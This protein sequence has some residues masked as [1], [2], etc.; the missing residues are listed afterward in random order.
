MRVTIKPDLSCSEEF[1][2]AVN[3]GKSELLEEFVASNK[4]AADI[5]YLEEV[6]RAD[7]CTALLC[8]VK[9]ADLVTAQILTKAGARTVVPST[10][11]SALHIVLDNM[12]PDQQM[13]DFLLR[14]GACP[15]IPD[16]SGRTAMEYALERRASADGY[17][18]TADHMGRCVMSFIQARNAF[19]GRVQIM[20]KPTGS[21]SW[22]KPKP[23]W[24]DRWCAL[25]PRCDSKGVAVETELLVF[26]K[27]KLRLKAT[28]TATRAQSSQQ[29]IPL[30]DGA[31]PTSTVALGLPRQKPSNMKSLEGFKC[32]SLATSGY[33]IY[34]GL[35]T[36]AGTSSSSL[37]LFMEQVAKPPS[38]LFVSSSPNTASPLPFSPPLGPLTPQAAP[39]MPPVAS[40]VAPISSIPPS[41]SSA[42][43]VTA[44]SVT[45]PRSVSTPPAVLSV[46]VPAAASETLTTATPHPIPSAPPCVPSTIETL[47]H[48]LSATMIIPPAECMTLPSA[49]AIGT[50]AQ[51][52]QSDPDSSFISPSQLAHPVH[53][54]TIISDGC[55]LDLVPSSMSDSHGL[56]QPHSTTSG[57]SHAQPTK[58]RAAASLVSSPNPSQL[59]AVAAARL[60]PP[61]PV[62]VSRTVSFHRPAHLLCLQHDWQKLA[63]QC[64]SLGT[65]LQL[66][67]QGEVLLTGPGTS[68]ADAM[69]VVNSACEACQSNSS[70][71]KLN[72]EPHTAALFTHP[73]V[74]ATGKRLRD[75]M[76]KRH[77]VWCEESSANRHAASA[78]NGI[79]VQVVRGNLTQQQVAAIV[80]PTNNQLGLTGGVSK[81]IAKAAGP[82]LEK[83]CQALLASLPAGQR[84]VPVGSSAVT[85]CRGKSYKSIPCQHIIHAVGPHYNGNSQLD[86]P[87][88]ASTVQSVLTQAAAKGMHSVAM[89]LIGAGLAG[90][91]PKLAA[92]VHVAQ[93]W[94]FSGSTGVPLKEVR[95]VDLNDEAIAALREQV[96][97]QRQSFSLSFVGSPA[98]CAAA[99]QDMQDQIQGH[100]TRVQ[101]RLCSFL[102][103]QHRQDMLQHYVLAAVLAQLMPDSL[104]LEGCKELVSQAENYVL[105]LNAEAYEEELVRRQAL[106]ADWTPMD[107][108]LN[109]QLFEVDSASPE[110]ASLVQALQQTGA[111][112]IKVH[113]IQNKLLWAAY[114]SSLA[115]MKVR[116][117]LE[118][119]L[120]LVNGGAS[121]LWH[122]TSKADPWDICAAEFGFM[123]NHA[124]LNGLWGYG[125]YYSTTPSLALSYE[126]NVSSTDEGMQNGSH[127]FGSTKDLKQLIAVDVLTGNAKQLAQDKTLR[128]PPMLEDGSIGRRMRVAGLRYDSVTGIHPHHNTPIFVTYNS[129]HAYPKYLITYTKT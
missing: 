58:Q 109:T 5:G 75:S 103:K 8:A 21:R 98:D 118:P 54:P 79:H 26:S 9:K 23:V 28:L 119:K 59:T 55:Q 57:S 18:R 72:L 86:V 124:R 60:V 16:K 4:H 76:K 80:N 73:A 96:A 29:S 95:F 39:P 2:R 85:S 12:G 44:S 48:F 37:A 66:R 114:A 42:A 47:T 123:H 111:T 107:D 97:L 53:N 13:L 108:A 43:R 69:D 1:F 25:V 17:Y 92:Q 62:V 125:T 65:D 74:Q 40:T 121:T 101:I 56:A 82:D 63:A 127:S 71:Q 35:S 99:M 120:A 81:H 46:S 90:W 84:A 94:K 6:N 105:R 110:V 51:M 126:H 102:D 61:P 87:L 78:L 113:R 117:R 122:G 115:A 22:F 27:D 129:G 10:G 11:Q 83:A 38:Q 14:H 106:P 128:M 7:G 30:T 77:R 70:E 15:Y 88:L 32:M 116:W 64:S 49:S 20:V 19:A 93:V 33:V 31:A 104:S 34:L 52:V 3:S 50:Q 91:P 67:A 36:A 112:I 100:M 68:F 45:M 41:A 89:P 24:K